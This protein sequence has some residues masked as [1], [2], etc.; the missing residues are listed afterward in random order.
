MGNLRTFAAAALLA[1]LALALPATAQDADTPLDK[2]LQQVETLLATLK[3]QP[4]ADAKTV[5][6]LEEIAANLRKEKDSRPGA[7]GGGTGGGGG[8]PAPWTGGGV[9]SAILARTEESF[10]RG[11]DL[12]EDEKA[13]GKAVILEFLVDYGI[14]KS[15]EDEKSKAVITDHTEKRI[16]KSFV[17]K[18]A[19]K[20]KDNL[21][22]IIKFWEG[23]WGRGGR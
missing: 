21:D 14:A 4:N 17:S 16:S 8:T 15:H 22:G 11:T 3:A 9:D 5:S 13:V 18:D 10:F 19:N 2:A 23:R 20:M 12:K 7:G 1:G 6:K